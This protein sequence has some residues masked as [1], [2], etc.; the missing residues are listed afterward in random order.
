MGF[1][2]P[3]GEGRLEKELAEWREIGIKPVREDDP[4]GEPARYDPD[5]ELLDAQIQKLES[6]SREPVDWN[7][8]VALGRKILQQKSKDLLVTSYLALGLL[9][10]EGFSGLSKGIAC[11]EGMISQ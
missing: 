11:L 8:V 7:Q 9:Q 1:G 3:E 2:Q 4:C 6:L 10:N 5:F